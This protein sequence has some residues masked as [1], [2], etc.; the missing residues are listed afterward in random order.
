MGILALLSCGENIQS[1]AIEYI[2]SFV[3]FCFVFIV[4]VLYHV[5]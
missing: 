4:E 5:E 1:F 3:L 2:I